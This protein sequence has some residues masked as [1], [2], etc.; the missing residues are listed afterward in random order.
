MTASTA[1][2]LSLS[3]VLLIVT[4]MMLR[5]RRRALLICV[6]HNAAWIIALVIVSSG[7][8][9]YSPTSAYAWLL[10]ILAIVAFNGGLF[11]SA[12]DRK[13]S[14]RTTSSTLIS[15]RTYEGLLALFA[16]GV[17]TYLKT[18]SDHYGLLTLFTNP[19]SIRATTNPSYLEAFP[20]YGKVLFYLGP[21]C[22]V[23]TLFPKFVIGLQRWPRWARLGTVAAIVL[24][25]AL[26]LQRTNIFMG[27]GWAVG[28]FLLEWRS[29]SASR[30]RADFRRMT[31]SLVAVGAVG[32]VAFQG[33]A[34]FT[35]KTGLENPAVTSAVSPAM[36]HSPFLGLLHYTS[37]GLPAFGHLVDSKDV[38]WPSGQ[39]YGENNP[40]TWGLATFSAPLKLVPGIRHWNDISPFVRLPVPTN[41]FTS[42]E[43]W[44]R[45]FRWP[46]I[47]LGPLAA[48]LALGFFSRKGATSPRALLTAGLLL[49][50]TCLT[51][52]VNFYLTVSSLVLYASIFLLGRDW[53]WFSG[54]RTHGKI[55]A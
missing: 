15:M 43:P 8:M 17:L 9:N 19:N 31:I 13:I 55:K 54:W 53:Y 52:F 37:S 1:T 33:I 23:L 25:Q 2:A 45:D 3:L 24:L 32:L 47:L 46:G 4:V 5:S 22:L 29:G 38:S 26:S 36:R 50:A 28:L 48:G 40:Q 51:T 20:L 21:L 11:L 16:L 49:G 10:I 34:V 35:G 7:L 44:Y 12:P 42:L 18:I 27:L 14:D 41:V 30:S 39:Y 6:P